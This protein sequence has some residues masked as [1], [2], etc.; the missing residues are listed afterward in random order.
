MVYMQSHGQTIQASL[1]FGGSEI[2][3]LNSITSTHDGGF[4][5]TGFSASGGAEFGNNQGN[6]D[7]LLAKI[8]ADLKVRKIKTWGTTGRDAALQIKKSPRGGFFLAGYSGAGDGNARENHGNLDIWVIHLNDEG[9]TIWMHCYGS[10]GN[11]EAFGLVALD[12]GGCLVAGYTTEE[13]SNSEVGFEKEKIWLL[14]LDTVGRVKWGK[15]YGTSDRNI[16]TCV[17]EIEN[18]GFLIGGFSSGSVRI[19]KKRKNSAC[20]LLRLD[21]NGDTL[22]TKKYGGEGEDN[23]QSICKT[24]EGGYLLVGNSNYPDGDSSLCKGQI[25]TWLI[26]V[27]SLGNRLWSKV[28][29]GS[30]NDVIF[31]IISF[32]GND[33]KG[34]AMVGYTESSDHEWQTNPNKG[35]KDLWL[36]IVDEVGK[37]ISNR[38]FGGSENDLGLS[39]IQDKL[40]NWLICGMTE[41]EDGDLSENAGQ[42]DAWVLR[43]SNAESGGRK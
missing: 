10:S 15:K 30:Q 37:I 20:L 17:Q 26:R 1:T 25:D 7:L 6:W 16:A 3:W 31:D 33:H 40:G 18:G 8:N 35:K 11:D 4:L 27:D 43:I 14:R 36:L 9:D 34:F 24:E 38:S 5:I 29:G 2:D 39:I 12:D 28:Y 13:K 22:W 42:G 41:S 23:L 19:D 32:S 21:K